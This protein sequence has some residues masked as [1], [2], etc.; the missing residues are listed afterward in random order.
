MSTPQQD[1]GFFRAPK[2]GRCSNMCRLCAY[3]CPVQA[4]YP[5]TIKLS[6]SPE[7]VDCRVP[8]VRVW[9]GWFQSAGRSLPSHGRPTLIPRGA[10]WDL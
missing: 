1:P 9:S 4:S 6:H 10:V 2:V 5:A 8:L 7:M 3:G